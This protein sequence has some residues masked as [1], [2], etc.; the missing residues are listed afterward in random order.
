[1][2]DEQPADEHAKQG[3]DQ[4]H[5]S[6][7][8][9]A[10]VVVRTTV[11]TAACA[12]PLAATA[13]AL[14]VGGRHLVLSRRRSEIAVLLALHPEGP[15]A[16]QLA[17]ELFGDQGKLGSVRAELSRMRRLLGPALDAPA[18]HFATPIRADL[19]DVL[20]ALDAG[21]AREALAAHAGELPP[22]SAAPG[23]VELRRGLDAAVRAAVLAGGAGADQV[24]RRRR[25]GDRSA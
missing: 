21:R 11:P 22:A 16:E 2:P 10:S 15:F 23:T 24:M 19:L 8:F 4:P 18:Y 14:E 6:L 9:H 12:E 25:G 7:P 20:A 5:G 17:L 3:L 13:A 1:V